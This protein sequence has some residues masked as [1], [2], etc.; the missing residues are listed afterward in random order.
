MQVAENSTPD[1]SF[2]CSLWIFRI[3]KE[4]AS[5]L[6]HFLH[7]VFENYCFKSEYDSGDTSIHYITLTHSIRK[8]F[9]PANGKCPSGCATPDRI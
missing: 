5:L 7:S 4:P 1:F 9:D 8:G 3:N 6:V 2:R